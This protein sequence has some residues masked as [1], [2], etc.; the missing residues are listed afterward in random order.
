VDTA[1]FTLEGRAM[2]TVRQP[3][4][5]SHR[6]AGSDAGVRRAWGPLFD[7]YGVDLVV[8]GHEHHYERSHPVRGTLPNEARTPVPVA[9]RTDVIDTGKGTVHMVIGAG[10][11][12]ATSQDD[13]FDTPQARVLV[14]L[15]D[16][17]TSSGHREPVWIPEEAPWAAVQDRTYNRGFAAF[18]VDPGD[19]R[20]GVTR[21]RVTY[22][23]FDGPHGDL[24][25]VDTF[26]LQRPRSDARH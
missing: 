2:R 15:K 16:D 7:A 14:G 8:S 23:T 1:E 17:K 13:L 10:G 24:T 4:I 18:D 11:N 19:R 20:E 6:S 21:M 5:S 26:S 12:I 3:M 25:P 9:T 22:Y